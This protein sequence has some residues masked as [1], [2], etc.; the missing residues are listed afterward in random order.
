M[1]PS[2]VNPA[3]W[4]SIEIILDDPNHQYSIIFG[5]F[6][7][8]PC[9]G[10]RWNGEPHERGYPGQA[11]NPLWFVVPEP[12]ERAILDEMVAIGNNSNVNQSSLNHA[13]QVLL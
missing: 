4:D 10:M 11:G 12:L 13:R 8:K 3:A 6:W 5:N 1:D 9:L 2:L 7:G